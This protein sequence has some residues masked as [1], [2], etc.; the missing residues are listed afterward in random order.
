MCLF[1]FLDVLHLFYMLEGHLT[2]DY[3]LT[4]M[5]LNVIIAPFSLIKHTMFNCDMLS[6]QGRVG[7]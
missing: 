7:I 4:L 3:V 1:L 6:R 2:W 5:F